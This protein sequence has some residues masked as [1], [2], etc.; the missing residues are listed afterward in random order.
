MSDLEDV[1]S[2]C[3]ATPTDLG[4]LKNN[5]YL[6]ENP[7]IKSSYSYEGSDPQ[8]HVP[9]DD[10]IP[11]VLT[12]TLNTQSILSSSSLEGGGRSQKFFEILKDNYPDSY[13]RTITIFIDTLQVSYII[14]YLNLFVVPIYFMNYFIF[15]VL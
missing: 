12:E 9:V 11:F 5:E 15:T 2:N 14:S 1:L 10:E 6:S 3:S 7:E 8:F 4:S 13:G